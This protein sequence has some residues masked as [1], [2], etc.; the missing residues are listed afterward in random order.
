MP[1][2][3]APL[4]ANEHRRHDECRDELDEIVVA[5]REEAEVAV[6]RGDPAKV[7]GNAFDTRGMGWVLCMGHPPNTGVLALRS[8]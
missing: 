4:P 6:Y 3:P 5:S 2:A 7:V 1:D 8:G